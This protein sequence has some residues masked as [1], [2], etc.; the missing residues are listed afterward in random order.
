MVQSADVIK[1]KKISMLRPSR[2]VCPSLCPAANRQ[3]RRVVV[4]CGREGRGAGGRRRGKKRRG[5]KKTL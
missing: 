3:V 4:G 2:Q 5:E 1:K